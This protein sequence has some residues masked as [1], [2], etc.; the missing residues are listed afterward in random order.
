MPGLDI[1]VK[2]AIELCVL[3]LLQENT[4]AQ[5][6]QRDRAAAVCCD[7]ML[8]NMQ[9]TFSIELTFIF[10]NEKLLFLKDLRVTYALHL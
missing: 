8:Y 1:Y 4:S 2:Q 9:Q 3:L 7:L 5:L 6:T 10:K